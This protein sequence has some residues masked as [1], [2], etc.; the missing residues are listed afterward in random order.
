[1]RFSAKIGIPRA[2]LFALTCM[3]LS[4]GAPAQNAT[5]SL[6]GM[7]QDSS[8]ARIPRAELTV[9]AQGSAYTRNATTNDRGEFRLDDL[10]PGDYRLT[11]TAPGFGEASTEVELI[12]SSVRD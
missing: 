1:M 2:A 10:Q 9:K 5:G 3:L 8:G 4:I 11:V 12:V 6:R 7:V